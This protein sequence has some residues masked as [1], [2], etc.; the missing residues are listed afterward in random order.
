MQ[1][2]DR[3][4]RRVKLRD[5]HVLL[6]VA[7]SGS[8]TKAAS[9]LAISHPV[10][11]KTITDLERTVGV[12][13]FDRNPHGV[14]LTAY[15]QAML[16]CGVAVFD[17]MRQGLKRIES[18]TGAVAGDLRIGC[19]EA[20]AAG[21]LPIVVERLLDRHPG[22]RLLVQ[23][24]DTAS[25]QFQVLRARSAELLLGPIPTPFSEDDLNA[26]V[27]FEQPFFVVAGTCSPWAR[28]RH[29][30]M[31]DL[32]RERW[33]LPPPDSVPGRLIGEIFQALKLPLPSASMVN[34]SIHATTSLVATGKF[35]ALFPG[36]VAK[37]AAKQLPLK[38]LPVKLPPRRVSV[39][40]VTVKHRTISPLA[41]LFIE[42]TS[43][44]AKSLIDD[45]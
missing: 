44:I 26:D 19:P 21:L 5:L 24:A 25:G 13:L 38:M 36:Y 31:S 28:R 42:C 10:I 12:R 15:G 30:E 14:E 43:G 22:I 6:A 7:Q 23:F 16:E 20:M 3:I 4:G 37:F 41:K 9:D 18:L 2:A 29:V 34:L 11:S 32:M 45:R 35:V 40:V 17:E 39:G 27:L 8:M 1:W 33:I